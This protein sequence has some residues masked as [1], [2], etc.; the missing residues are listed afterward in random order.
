MSAVLIQNAS[1]S[2]AA[3]VLIPSLLVLGF[4]LRISL[5]IFSLP[6][7]PLAE[8]LRPANRSLRFVVCYAGHSS[9]NCRSLGALECTWAAS[10][11]CANGHR[12]PAQVI[13]Y[14]SPCVWQFYL[15]IAAVLMSHLETPDFFNSLFYLI[16]QSI[17]DW[18]ML[19]SNGRGYWLDWSPDALVKRQHAWTVYIIFSH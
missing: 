8:V 18:A 9:Y 7:R 13:E 10:P 19:S 16:E 1:H 17:T 3:D 4:S 15:M 2:I 14:L 12:I 6:Q 11:V 5:K